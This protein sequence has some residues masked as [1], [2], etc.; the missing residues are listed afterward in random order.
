MTTPASDFLFNP[1]EEHRM[2]RQMVAD[3]ARREVDPQAAE[4][5]HKGTLNVALFRASA[6]S[7]CSASPCPRPTAA[8]AWTPSPP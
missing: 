2:L 3:F 7:A 4:H 1:T 8:P 6:S 5:D